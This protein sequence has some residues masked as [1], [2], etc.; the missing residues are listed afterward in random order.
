MHVLPLV[1]TVIVPILC[2]LIVFCELFSLT[3]CSRARGIMFFRIVF[4]EIREFLRGRY[5]CLLYLLYF[6]MFSMMFV[7]LKSNVCNLNLL[8]V[9]RFLFE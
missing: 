8:N 9:N 4:A 7:L 5:A 2:E 1:P 6:R 3:K